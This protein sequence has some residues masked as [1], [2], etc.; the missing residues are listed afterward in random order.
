MDV[1][2]YYQKIR[3]VEATIPDAF[4]VVVSRVTGDGGRDGVTTEVTRKVAAKMLVEGFA[5]LATAD[6]VKTYQET[7]AA[8][9]RAA[10]DAA[11]AAR[12]EVTVVSTEDLK[13]LRSGSRSAKE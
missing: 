1:R 9:Y 10:Q 13:K 12:V 6:E 3:D 4:P 8:A 2:M 7:Q 5:S 11:A